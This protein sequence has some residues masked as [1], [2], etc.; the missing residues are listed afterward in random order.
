MTSCHK[1]EKIEI[2]PLFDEHVKLARDSQYLA[3][4]NAIDP[5]FIEFHS[6]G[7][8][9]SDSESSDYSD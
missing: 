5:D 1:L 9:E 2:T 3:T 7:L 4:I 8:I 6:S